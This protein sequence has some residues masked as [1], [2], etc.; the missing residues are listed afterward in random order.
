MGGWRL[1]W[2]NFLMVIKKMQ[3][4][5]LV[6]SRKILSLCLVSSFKVLSSGPRQSVHK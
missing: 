4:W 5:R 2:V 3:R 6:L 1:K